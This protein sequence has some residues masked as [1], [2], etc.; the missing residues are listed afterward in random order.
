MKQK[1]LIAL[2]I[3]L[4]VCGVFFKE[5]VYVLNPGQQAVVTQFGKPIGK[6]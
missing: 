3:I 5:S 6:P 1:S 4:V 2:V